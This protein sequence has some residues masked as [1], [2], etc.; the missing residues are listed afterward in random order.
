MNEDMKV[1]NLR[2]VDT[3]P[4]FSLILLGEEY[5]RRNNITD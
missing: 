1:D 2:F 4:F 3:Y 5:M